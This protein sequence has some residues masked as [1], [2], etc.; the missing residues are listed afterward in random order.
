LPAGLLLYDINGKKIV[1]TPV[2]NNVVKF[3]T[4]KGKLVVLK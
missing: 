2:E 4:R 3:E 1:V